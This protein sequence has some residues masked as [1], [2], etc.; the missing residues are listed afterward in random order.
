M[1]YFKR[2]EQTLLFLIHVRESEA[3]KRKEIRGVAGRKDVC[4]TNAREVSVNNSEGPPV[5]IPNTEVK[6]VCAY[7][8]WL[9]TA[10]DDRSMLTLVLRPSLRKGR[11]RR[12]N[13][14]V[15]H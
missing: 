13:S 11:T 9:D 2:E 1:N 8:T 10:R 12:G 7:N 15:G 3:V 6:L 5:P 4:E 14:D